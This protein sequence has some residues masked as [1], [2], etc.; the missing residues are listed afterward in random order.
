[1]EIIFWGATDDVTGSLTFL[2]LP[3]GLIAVDCGMFQGTLETMKLNDLSLPFPPSE[4]KAVILTHAHLDHSGMLPALVKKGFKGPIYCTKATAYLAK[5]I[6]MDSASLENQDLY[7]EE[8][9][10]KAI[11][12]IQ[13]LE[14]N[15][16]I[17]ILGASIKLLPAGHILGASSVKI[18]A[19]NKTIVFSGDLG[20]DNDPLIPAPEPCPEADVVIMESTYGNRVRN[21]NIE[22]EL[23]S[24]LMTVS[25][26]SRVGIIASFAVARGQLLIT[27]IN[28]FFSRHP[29]EKV[30]VVMDGP[31]MSDA[32]KIYERFSDLTKMPQAV[33]QSLE[34][35]EQLDFQ[36]QWESFKKK[37][38]PLIIISSSGML[39]GGRI[40][41]HLANW[42][43]DPKAILFLPGYQAEGTPGRAFLE[44]ER[45]MKGP[46][47]EIIRWS[48]EVLSS[49]AFS[50]HAD[51]NELISWTKNL[52]EGAKVFLIHG[53]EAA[54]NA[55]GAKLTEKKLKVKIPFRSEAV[56]I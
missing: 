2:K 3:E 52:K 49:D 48:G 34:N 16:T 36:G 53:D 55:L 44:G 5:I 47:E 50:S 26:E 29:E 28:E 45:T 17:N 24:F 8:D 54:K 35:I 31:M 9:A 10:M 23:H 42:Q 56:L 20:R 30:R 25:R 43:D 19:E 46:D 39:T 41:R 15:E 51:Q 14:W 37:G 11:N 21:G 7:S 4:L 27:L 6:L 40:G 38:G 33:E 13:H 18:H 22:K 1:M 12:R 32:N